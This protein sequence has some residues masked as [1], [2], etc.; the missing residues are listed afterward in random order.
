MNTYT[1]AVEFFDNDDELILTVNTDADLTNC[2]E[3]ILRSEIEERL[4]E[5]HGIDMETVATWDYV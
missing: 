5:D 1:I 4:V 2:D 3:D